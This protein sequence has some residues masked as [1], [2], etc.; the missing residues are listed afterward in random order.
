MGN[1]G[2]TESSRG[3]S[4]AERL[5][6]G[7]TVAVASVLSFLLLAGPVT[8][9]VTTTWQ[10]VTGTGITA[11]SRVAVPVILLGLLTLPLVLAL[12]VFRSGRTRGREPMTAAVPAT[13]TLLGG[14]VVPFGALVLIFVFA[15]TS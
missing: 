8:I 10:L 1:T 11:F 12:R 14:S 5:V 6:E 15:H 7:L 3:R 4:R 2:T 13:L 9:F